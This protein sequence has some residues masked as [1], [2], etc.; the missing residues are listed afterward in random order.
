MAKANKHM[1]NNTGFIGQEAA[2]IL[3]AFAIVANVSQILKKVCGKSE[4]LLESKKKFVYI[5]DD[6]GMSVI[7]STE[8][9]VVTSIIGASTI[10]LMMGA[11]SSNISNQMD[12]SNL[13]SQLS[14]ANIENQSS[15]HLYIVDSDI[16]EPLDQALANQYNSNTTSIQATV[17]TRSDDDGA[18]SVG[19]GDADIGVITHQ[20]TASE[21]AEYPQLASSMIGG[22]A[23]VIIAHTDLT[24]LMTTGASAADFRSIYSQTSTSL[25]SNVSNVKYAVRD[26][27]GLGSDDIFANWISNGMTSSLDQYQNDQNGVT[28]VDLNSENAVINYVS[29]TPGAIGY[30]D[31][32]MVS[33]NDPSVTHFNVIP[34]VNSANGQ[35]QA[36]NTATINNELDNMNNQNYDTGLV[37]QIYYIYNH[38]PTMTVSNYLQYVIHTSSTLID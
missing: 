38:N 8:I 23:I 33:S 26:V 34:V 13:S 37:R 2:I 19:T 15:L 9:L 29:S 14:I 31:W 32:N 11:Y 17:S 28:I 25:A 27:D 16:T 20:L 3:I 7:I 24:S 12:T 10:A 21:T 35:L 36:A 1:K 18:V 6:Y 4:N 22:R 30:V 5:F